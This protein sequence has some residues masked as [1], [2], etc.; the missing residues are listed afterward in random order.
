[1]RTKPSS[2]QD[3]LVEQVRDLGAWWVRAT[4]IQD[5]QEYGLIEPDLSYP[6]RGCGS[7][8]SYPPATAEAVARFA[9]LVRLLRSIDA[10]TIALFLEGFPVGGRGIKRALRKIVGGM[11]AASPRENPWTRA[12]DMARKGAKDRSAGGR[13]FRQ[14][15][16]AGLSREEY[17]NVLGDLERTM[18]GQPAPINPSRSTPMLV[19]SL[20]L[21]KEY[22]EDPD[23]TARIV[24]SNMSRATKKS[25]MP[26]VEEATLGDLERARELL[27]ALPAFLRANP[28]ESIKPGLRKNMVMLYAGVFLTAVQASVFERVSVKVG[29]T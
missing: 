29:A 3:A 28:I 26:L 24:N 15:V 18:L 23:G 25:L 7:I 6:G 21:E 10:A 1:V 12:K 14:F 27:A 13:A 22:N 8:S 2:A 4:Q 11:P 5:W 16:G 19:R 20:H 9:Q 17:E